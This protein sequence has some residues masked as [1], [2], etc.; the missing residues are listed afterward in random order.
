M[1]IG[2]L[3]CLAWC[4]ASAEDFAARCDDR[5]AIEHVYYTHRLGAKPPFETT[6]SRATLERLVRLD[7]TREA[8]LQRQ[9]GVVITPALLAGEVQRINST[10]RAPEMLAEIKAALNQDPEKFAE[11]FARPFLV[12]RLLRQH[13]DNDD[14]LHAG[15][16]QQCEQIRSRLL[17]ARTNGATPAQL[18]A[19]FQHDSS[20][21]VSE[22]AW[23]LG[24]PAATNPPASL[25]GSPPLY[26]GDLPAELQTVL[27][28]QLH[29]AGD[30][31]AVIETPASFLLY[32]VKNR[33]TG[34]L[35]VAC[36]TLP[37]RDFDQWLEE[38]ATKP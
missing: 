5:L 33:T 25:T 37:K 30:V 36:L 10:T 29:Q 14:R 20:N 19:Q 26:F 15:L 34:V 28:A 27:Q 3:M 31:S 8:V 13:F 6:L 38:Q 35:Q 32:L 11:A 2:W 24:T 12:E 4:G 21:Q 16:R 17:A 18:L 1:G 7:L 22:V 9:Y 23:Q